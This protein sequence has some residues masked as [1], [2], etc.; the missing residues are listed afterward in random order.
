[1][2]EEYLEDLREAVDNLIDYIAE[3]LHLYEMMDWIE[4]KLRRW[5]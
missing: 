2:I 3:S 1:M 4:K 5:F